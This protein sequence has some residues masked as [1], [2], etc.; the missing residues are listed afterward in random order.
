[1]KILIP[2]LCEATEKQSV[3]NTIYLHNYK[4]TEISDLISIF[5]VV[6][7]FSLIST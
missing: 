1:M 6:F 2:Q 5:S 3:F 7:I 4:A